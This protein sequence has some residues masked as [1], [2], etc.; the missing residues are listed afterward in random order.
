[1]PHQRLPGG[2]VSRLG[3]EEQLLE[4]PRVLPGT[5]LD[6]RRAEHAE[7]GQD[8]GAVQEQ[9]RDGGGPQPGTRFR[10]LGTG[11]GTWPPAGPQDTT[12]K[13]FLS[14]DSRYFIDE[15]DITRA[16]GWRSFPIT[17]VGS[18]WEVAVPEA[19]S[20]RSLRSSVAMSRHRSNHNM[21]GARRI[22]RLHSSVVA[23][24]VG[25]TV[26]TVTQFGSVGDLVMTQ[27]PG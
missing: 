8:V 6:L 15:R 20:R 19:D 1:M 3:T 11:L 27:D 18:S 7:G 24:N 10:G 12:P 16:T 21:C 26:W 22:G 2:G 14:F 23:S 25:G 4:R 17:Q 13:V 9:L 5:V